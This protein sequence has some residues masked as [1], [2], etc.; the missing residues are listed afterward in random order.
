MRKVGF[1]VFFLVAVVGA[2]LLVISQVPLRRESYDVVETR[3]FSS[4][5][6]LTF[7]WTFRLGVRYRFEVKGVDWTGPHYFSV[8]EDSHYFQTGPGLVN[9]PWVWEWS[10]PR[11][12]VTA[13]LNVTFWNLKQEIDRSTTS[14]FVEISEL[15]ETTAKPTYLIY[16]G[17]P[18][19]V[20]GAILIM[21]TGRDVDSRKRHL[22]SKRPG[23]FQVIF[24]YPINVSGMLEAWQPWQS[25]LSIHKF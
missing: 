8:L 13:T 9:P 17:L 19:L 22:K 2:V 7:F 24:D 16:V 21:V 18:L 10:Y 1:A 23:K 5:E 4:G 11:Y 3:S 20:I 15:K 6:P 25:V 14:T 12:A